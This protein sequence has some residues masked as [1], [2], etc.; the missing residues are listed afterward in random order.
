MTGLRK[1][2]VVGAEAAARRRRRA[3]V[4][5][6]SI[7][8]RRSDGLTAGVDVAMVAGI[9]A[10]WWRIGTRSPVRRDPPLVAAT[11][12]RSACRSSAPSRSRSSS[13]RPR[14]IRP[15]QMGLLLDERADT[16]DVTATIIDLAVRGYLTITEI[17]KT[18]W[19]GRTDWQIDA[20]EEAD[21]RSCSTTSASCS[22]AL[23]A[24]ATRRSCPSSRTSSTRTSSKAKSAL[25]KDAVGAAGFR[26][27][28]TRS[29]RSLS[30]LGIFV[31]H[32]R[33]VPDDR[34]RRAVGRRAARPADRSSAGCCSRS[35]RARC[36]G[37]RRIGREL[38]RA[39][40]RLRELHQDRGDRASRRSPSAPT[41]SRAYLP[42]A[43]VFK[44]VDHWARAF[45]DID[46]QAATG[47]WY[48]GTTP[49]TPARSRPSVGSFSSSVS[50]TIAST[51]GGSGSSGFSG[52]SSGGGG[53]GGGRRQLVIDW[54]LVRS[55]DRRSSRRDRR[56]AASTTVW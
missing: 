23:F 49:S 50:S 35:R 12:P 13:S 51:P 6:C 34:P 2:A 29:A 27:I 40:A 5:T 21:G 16:L 30:F 36:R 38:M 17:P 44:C 7:V 9:G 37:A 19:F 41:S 43:I 52:G 14:Q 47:G 8:R 15:G 45:K 1:G 11:T 4:R 53:G 48:V 20:T 32:R 24:A 39:I 55:C 18:G 22:T 28:R 31:H 10:L 56:R 54:G 46:L 25:Y 3:T 26:G 33:R 42:Y